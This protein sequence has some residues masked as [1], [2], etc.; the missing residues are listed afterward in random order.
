VLDPSS[1]GPTIDPAQ[2]DPGAP[3]P[4]IDPAQLERG[5]VEP[6]G[7]AEPADVAGQFLTDPGLTE[8]SPPG[9]TT[10]PGQDHID[11]PLNLG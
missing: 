2:L 8:P 11:D 1:P 4:T 10:T 5:N 3:G 9:P 6:G 7:V